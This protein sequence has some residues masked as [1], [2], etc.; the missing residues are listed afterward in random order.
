MWWFWYN[1][2][3]QQFTTVLVWSTN[4]I[5]LPPTHYNLKVHFTHNAI[6]ILSHPYTHGPPVAPPLSST[7]SSTPSGHSLGT[8][9]CW[10][11]LH[12][13]PLERSSPTSLVVSSGFWLEQ[14]PTGL[15][16][17]SPWLNLPS[18][19][20]VTNFLHTH[21]RSL[22]HNLTPLTSRF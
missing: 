18:S 13:Y 15:P 10:S 21:T 14:L 22:P 1:S 11:P 17:H 20:L 5:N 8:P 16:A 6:Q 4:S 19:Y 9:G 7:L 3:I 2:D 12:V